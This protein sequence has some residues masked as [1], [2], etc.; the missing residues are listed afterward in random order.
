MRRRT[1]S[2][3]LKAMVRAPEGYAIVGADVDPEELWISSCMGDA[4][5][6]LHGATGIG[7]M[8]L[9]GTKAAGTDLHSKTASI[10][11]IWRDQA[12]ASNYSR[13]YGAEMKPYFYYCTLTAIK[14]SKL[15]QVHQA[16]NL[17][18]IRAANNRAEPSAVRKRSAG[19]CAMRAN[20]EEED[21]MDLYLVASPPSPPGSPLITLPSLPITLPVEVHRPNMFCY[22]CRDGGSALYCCGRCPTV[23]CDG[24]LIIPPEYCNLVTA[25]EV[26][27]TCPGC[28]ELQD[29]CQGQAG[30]AYAPY[31]VSLAPTN[32]YCPH[33]RSLNR[34]LECLLVSGEWARMLILHLFSKGMDTRGTTR[35]I[36]EL[37]HPYFFD[38]TLIFEELEFEF[39]TAAKA[40]LY[41]TQMA[42]HGEEN[43]GD[44]FAG[45]DGL[46]TTLSRWPSKSKKKNFLI[47][48]LQWFESLLRR[49]APLLQGATIVL[50]SCSWLVKYPESFKG[51]QM[52]L[53]HMSGGTRRAD[54]TAIFAPHLSGVWSSTAL[55]YSRE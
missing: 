35:L 53:Q 17:R 29:R 21:P 3:Q 48:L 25:P 46:P 44:S 54:L 47:P 50:L 14:S 39:G 32:R 40:R 19:G 12:T 9:K 6:G 28:H 49:A 37:L 45:D 30:R 5:F 7:W 4:Q 42:T 13:I 18:A 24:C 27:F 33:S 16:K 22:L 31:W 2:G 11:G 43:R 15:D 34:I 1:G 10:L 51:P 23:V 52:S 36:H 38:D 41:A 20:L 8:T 26:G 55:E